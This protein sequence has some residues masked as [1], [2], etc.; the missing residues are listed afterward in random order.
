MMGRHE[1]LHR[2]HDEVGQQRGKHVGQSARSAAGSLSAEPDGHREEE[3]ADDGNHRRQE[4]GQQVQGNDRPE[5]GPKPAM[6]LGDGR[7]H[8]ERNQDGRN[9]LQRP[10]KHLPQNTDARPLRTQQAECSA[11]HKTDQNPKDETRSRPLFQ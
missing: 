8:Q 10:D 1:G 3:T 7:S 2:I 11:D 9:G 5:P 4:G 6:G